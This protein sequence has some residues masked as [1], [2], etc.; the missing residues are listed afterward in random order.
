MEAYVNIEEEH[1]WDAVEDYVGDAIADKL[2][3]FIHEDDLECQ[4]ANMIEEKEIV[5]ADMVCD[6]TGFESRVRQL[7]DEQVSLMVVKNHDIQ[8]MELREH[9]DYLFNRINELEARTLRGRWDRLVDWVGRKFR[10]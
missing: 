5:P 9:V 1:I 3:E 4:L 7:E 10:G 8:M 6:V 2:T